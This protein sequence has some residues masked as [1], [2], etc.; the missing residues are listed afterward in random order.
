MESHTVDL[1]VIGAGSGGIAAA[2]RAASYGARV[3]LI[4]GRRI[5]GTCVLRGCVPKKLMMYAAG[6]AKTLEDANGYGWENVSGAFNLHKWSQAKSQELARLEGIYRQMLA[7]SGVQI[8]MGYAE[9]IGNSSVRVAQAVWQAPRIL[10]ATGGAPDVAPVPGLEQAMTSDDILDLQ[11]Q[12]ESLLVVGA[13][14]IGVEFASIMANLGVDVTLAYR[15]EWPLRGFDDELRKHASDALLACGVRLRP[16]IRMHSL[17]KQANAYVLHCDDGD[18]IS[19][20]AVLNA[21]GRRPMTQGLG[22]EATQVRV[23]KNGA[24]EVDEDGKTNA[25]GIWAIGD[26]TNRINL[27]PVAI[28][29]GRAFADTEF[30]VQQVRADHRRVGSAVFSYPP[31]ASVGLTEQQA[32]EQG[33]VDVYTSH[34]RPMYTAFINGQQR[35]L[36]KLLVDPRDGIVLGVHMLGTDAPE[37]IQALAVA[38]SAGAT[39]EHFDRTMAMHPTAAEEFVLM[40]TPTRQ[41]RST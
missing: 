13:G 17:D 36:M 3:V 39:K 38:L 2:R 40:R 29:E 16:K 28:A 7:E 18:A 6:I 14:Y 25:A 20:S 5:G 41:H 33:P 30:G 22:L 11:Q 37:I 10:I 24:I 12:P 4:E 1:I 15:G 34:F 27:T 21:T 8:V 35:T 31:I 9:L 23:D 26:V 32:K 19:A